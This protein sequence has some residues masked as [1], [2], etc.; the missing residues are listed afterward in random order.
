MWC[1]FKSGW[2]PPPDFCQNGPRAGRFSRWGWKSNVKTNSLPRM[3]YFL[4]FFN[5][6]KKLIVT[7]F[8]LLSH[9]IRHALWFLHTLITSHR[10]PTQYPVWRAHGHSHAF[11]PSWHQCKHPME[12]P[13]HPT[14]QVQR[15]RRGGSQ[16]VCFFNP[17]CWYCTWPCN[18][19]QS[20]FDYVTL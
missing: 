11:T 4:C 5:K 13:H 12:R 14:A 7:F 1:R 6:K 9:W 2:S 17:Y 10:S 8:S 3:E 20:S 19:L 15:Q 18:S 16:S